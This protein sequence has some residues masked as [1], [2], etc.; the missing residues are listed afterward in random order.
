MIK[1]KYPKKIR[2]I[3]KNEINCISKTNGNVFIALKSGYGFYVQEKLKEV[4]EIVER[5]GNDNLT[6]IE[7]KEKE[8]QNFTK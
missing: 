1:V 2:E 6:G 4:A 7:K 5:H 8:W 3:N